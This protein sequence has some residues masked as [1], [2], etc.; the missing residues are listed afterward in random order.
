MEAVVKD[1]SK[2]DLGFLAEYGAKRRALAGT[3]EAKEHTDEE[4]AALQQHVL[5]LW[6]TC[7]AEVHLWVMI[8]L[9]ANFSLSSCS[10]QA[11]VL[12]RCVRELMFLRTK[13]DRHPHYQ[14]VLATIKADP[15]ARYLVPSS[16]RS[17]CSAPTSHSPLHIRTWGAASAP[18]PGGSSWT[19]GRRRTS[20][21]ST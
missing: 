3:Q 6:N 21:P 13:V 19:A 18:T 7:L 17:P 15:H 8:Y 10:F 2:E 4:L 1:I 9:E 5:H 16:L 14:E 12:Y 11:T 20:W